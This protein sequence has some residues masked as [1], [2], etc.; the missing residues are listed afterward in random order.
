VLTFRLFAGRAIDLASRSD[1]EL[2]CDGLID[3]SPDQN[4]GVNPFEFDIRRLT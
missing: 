1:R 3:V 4:L 2:K